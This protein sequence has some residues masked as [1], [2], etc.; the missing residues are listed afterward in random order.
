MDV[1]TRRDWGLFF[2]GIALV[3]IGFVFLTVPGI[4]LV[5]VTSVAGAFLL[6]TGGFDIYAYAR[7]RDEM[8]LDG[9]TIAY[10]ICDIVLGA[11][12]LI[13]PVFFSA[14]I[15]WVAGVFMAAYGIFEIVAAARSKG[16][17]GR[18]WVVFNGIVS[19]LCALAFFLVPASFVIFLAFFLICRGV[20]LA[21]YGITI[22]KVITTSHHAA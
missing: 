16:V 10:A 3:I 8:G 13:H 21:V 22:D 14:V 18:G 12:L 1:K 15:P 19:L 6:V 5:A 20:T 9:W 7:Y 11:V 2:L 4:T 17:S